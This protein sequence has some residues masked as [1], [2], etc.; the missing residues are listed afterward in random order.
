[1]VGAD[2]AI[3]KLAVGLRWSDQAEEAVGN[4][5]GMRHRSAQRY[6]YDQPTATV[7]VVSEDGPVTVY[8]RGQVVVTKAGEALD[9]AMI[10]RPVVQG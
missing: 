7:V 2:G 4:D 1:V 9:P 8:R 5:R 6:S 3:R 10:A